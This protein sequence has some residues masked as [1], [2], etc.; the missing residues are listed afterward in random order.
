[1]TSWSLENAIETGNAMKSKGYGLKPRTSYFLF[2]FSISDGFF[3]ALTIGFTVFVLVSAASGELNFNFYPA[4][5]EI[6]L[7]P[8]LLRHI[9]C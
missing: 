3:M 5:S 1:M 2:K 6:N 9:L 4:L 8:Y 7:N